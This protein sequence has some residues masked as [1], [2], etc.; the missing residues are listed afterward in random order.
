MYLMQF[1]TNL[2]EYYDKQW[3]SDWQVCTLTPGYAVQFLSI[4]SVSAKLQ[5]YPDLQLRTPVH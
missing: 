3:Q 2:T 1:A 4:L 5:T